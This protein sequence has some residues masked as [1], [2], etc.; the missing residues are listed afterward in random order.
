MN[1]ISNNKKVL[2]LMIM[3]NNNISKYSKHNHQ[4]ST[5]LNK[6]SQKH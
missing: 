6:D 5:N 4:F 1:S 2:L 3:G